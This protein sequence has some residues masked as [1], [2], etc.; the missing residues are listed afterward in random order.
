MCS[1]HRKNCDFH[2]ECEARSIEGFE[3][4]NIGLLRAGEVR[5]GALEVKQ[6]SRVL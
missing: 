3:R 1:D 4:G 5:D 6:L 2:S